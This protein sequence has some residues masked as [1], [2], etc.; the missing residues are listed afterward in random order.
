MTRARVRSLKNA[1]VVALAFLLILLTV[2]CSRISTPEGWSAGVVKGD[3]L[4]IGTA[5]GSLLAVDKI[6]G[7]TLWRAAPRQDR[8]C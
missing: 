1:N 8:C 7:S 6:N 3:A 2:A 4:I 5:E